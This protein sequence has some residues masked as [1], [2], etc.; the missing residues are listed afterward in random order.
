[1]N[2]IGHF[3]TADPERGIAGLMCPFAYPQLHSAVLQHLWHK[4]QFVHS[5]A[6]IQ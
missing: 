5:A 1:M 2:G 3:S 6:S 4:G